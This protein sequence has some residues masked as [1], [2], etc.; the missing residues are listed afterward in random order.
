V[1]LPGGQV[2]GVC[3]SSSLS[4]EETE[5][6]PDGISGVDGESGAPA[7]PGCAQLIGRVRLD[8]GQAGSSGRVTEAEYGAGK[9]ISF[10]LG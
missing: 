6:H 9:A 7:I 4:V 2:E 10:S 8:V 1:V 5:L 3:L